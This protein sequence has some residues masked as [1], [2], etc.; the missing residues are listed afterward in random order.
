ML[1]IAGS[2]LLA[3]VS[4]FVVRTEDTSI[5]RP[6]WTR[7]GSEMLLSAPTVL[8]AAAVT[9]EPSS[10]WTSANGTARVEKLAA[11]IQRL[12][13]ENKALRDQ[14]AVAALPGS[15]SPDHGRPQEPPVPKVTPPMAARSK[16]VFSE[17]FGGAPSNPLCE[18]D[19]V[20]YQARA[21][22]VYTDVPSACLGATELA[23]L[24]IATRLAHTHRVAILL[25]ARRNTTVSKA[26]GIVLASPNDLKLLKHTKNFVFVASTSASKE[27]VQH[28]P[29]WVSRYPAAAKYMWVRDAR[30]HEAPAKAG[31]LKTKGI[32]VVAASRWHA[33]LLRSEVQRHGWGAA[34]TAEPSGPFFHPIG[35]VLSKPLTSPPVESTNTRTHLFFYGDSS[36]PDSLQPALDCTRKLHTMGHGKLQL[37]VAWSSAPQ[38]KLAA[39]VG[40][41][42]RGVMR[43]AELARNLRDALGL[44]FPSAYTQPSGIMYA[45]ANAAGCPVLADRND[46]LANEIMLCV[47]PLITQLEATPIAQVGDPTD[48]ACAGT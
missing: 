3:T 42:S 36:Q 9:A 11:V 6:T 19:V 37:H 39:T 30:A 8:P 2:L 32:V 4:V 24:D 40:V 1:A 27:L 16:H 47:T 43:R 26:T 5:L 45:E 25:Q 17:Y 7:D 46:V 15:G 28:F 31:I 35:D 41:I 12:G 29:A 22:C 48:R 34:S 20:F 14:L 38:P 21:S 13:D 18:V 23:V 44:L 10:G 33:K